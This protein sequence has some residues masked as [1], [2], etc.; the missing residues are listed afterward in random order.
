MTLILMIVLGKWAILET[1]EH[2]ASNGRI[3]ELLER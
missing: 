3:S 1:R 2:L